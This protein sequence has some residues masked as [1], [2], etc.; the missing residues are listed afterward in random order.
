MLLPPG[1][2]EVGGGVYLD[3]L[4]CLCEAYSGSHSSSDNS[5]SVIVDPQMHPWGGESRGDPPPPRA[6]AMNHIH[7]ELQKCTALTHSAYTFVIMSKDR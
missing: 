2:L 5:S 7:Q 3:N 1:G 6:A 4:G